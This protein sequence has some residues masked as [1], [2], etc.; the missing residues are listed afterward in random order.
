MDGIVFVL[1]E[2]M[3]WRYRISSEWQ[4][5]LQVTL[6]EFNAGASFPLIQ[7]KYLNK[8]KNYTNSG[9]TFYYQAWVHFLMLYNH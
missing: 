2:E 9:K 1:I 3:E 6:D 8:K 4:L 5:P 7:P